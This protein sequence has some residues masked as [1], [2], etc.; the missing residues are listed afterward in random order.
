MARGLARGALLVLLL[1]APRAAA[2]PPPD[3]PRA[4]H[5]DLPFHAD[6]GTRWTAAG[7]VL[8]RV[9]LEVPWSSLR[10]AREGSGWGT[11]FDVTIVAY[12]RGGNQVNGD[13]WTVPIRSAGAP[14]PGD[15][16][17]YRR[18][19]EMEVAPG[20]IRFEVKLDQTGSGRQG[21]WTQTLE[22][23]RYD[24]VP[25]ALSDFVFGRRDSAPADTPWAEGSFTP[26]PRRR[27]GDE[28]P[29]MCVSGE[30][31]DRVT[32]PDTTYALTW[33]VSTSSGRV[34]AAGADTLPRRDNR[35]AFLLQPS[36]ATLGMGPYSLRLE[37]RL[38]EAKARRERGFEVDESRID[39]MADQRMIR[40]VLG[41]IASNE[42]LVR[43]ES[44][45][46]DSLSSFWK[47]FWAR[48]DPTTGTG[49]NENMTEFLRRLEYA[50]A[51]FGGT[52]AGYS[53]DMGRIYIRYGAPDEVDRMP[54]NASSPPQEIWSYYA[55]G[56]RFVFV[57]QDGFGR[58]RLVRTVRL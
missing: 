21:T 23:P 47:E 8:A 24:A 58:Y 27:Y 26:S 45:P 4:S 16:R 6:V 43:L 46:A 55:R 5:G 33:Q 48:R 11:R 25:L 20:R 56:E 12:D 22:V 42:E 54:F 39:I 36:I 37:T 17:V 14:A 2:G 29:V 35:G 19:F 30:I 44:L 34:V 18:R 57:D 9:Y 50:N 52:E 38:A 10:F 49:R 53:S 28:Q 31:Y 51:N 41:Y 13:L 15:F 3:L 40:E 32:A 7:R 1:N